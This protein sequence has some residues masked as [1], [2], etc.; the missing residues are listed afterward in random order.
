MALAV[1]KFGGSSLADDIKLNIVADK[2]IS[3]QKKYEKLVVVVSAQGQTTNRL[4]KEAKRLSEIPND[5]EMDMLLSTG[6]QISAS[7]LSILLNE[8]GY[9]SIS[10]T[11][12]QVGI[13]T[14][15]IHQHASIDSIA[16]NRTL[17][18]L[19]DKIVIVT[20]FQGVDENNDITTLGRGGSDTSAVALSAALKA[21]KCYI[22]SDVDGIYSADPDF[23]IKAQKLNTISFD[24][25][26]EIADAGAKVLH[27]RCIQIGQ[28]FNLKVEAKS[29][30]NNVK[31]TEVVQKIENTAIKSIVKNDNLILFKIKSSSENIYQKLFLNNIFIESYKKYNNIITFIT[32]KENQNKIEELLDNN[33]EE[34]PIIKLSII[35][36]GI[37]NNNNIINTLLNILKKYAIEPVEFNLTESK[38]EVLALNIS[39]DVIRDI[40]KTLIEGE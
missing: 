29:T 16:I 30:F 27:N 15:N 28:R 12:W 38:L 2:I 20:G 36:Y 32:N 19:Q 37:R 18:E 33:Y 13:N 7:K 17:K 26:Q 39:N 40:H 22:Y 24:E 25:M 6:E 10:L 1:L 34:N 4:I 21:D 35:G 23:V 9:K 31:G 8:K 3:V 5:R 11:G 14:S